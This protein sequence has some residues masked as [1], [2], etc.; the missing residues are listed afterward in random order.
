M[1]A[2][3]TMAPKTLDLQVED[4]VKVLFGDGS[5]GNERA[6][7]R[8]CEEN[9]ETTLFLLDLGKSAVK[10]GGFGNVSLDGRDIGPDGRHRGVKLSLPTA[11]D[12]DMGPFLCELFRGCEAD[13][14]AS[15]GDE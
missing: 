4:R 8:V 1:E 3:R 12:V 7:S 9:V 11:C 13:A 6:T 5:E 14:I 2:V 10:I 15:A